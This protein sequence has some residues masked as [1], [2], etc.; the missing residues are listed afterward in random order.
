MDKA[1]QVNLL[2]WDSFYGQKDQLR[3]ILQYSAV[4]R[5]QLVDY[6]VNLIYS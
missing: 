2:H 1:T 3:N 4:V 6:A 5:R